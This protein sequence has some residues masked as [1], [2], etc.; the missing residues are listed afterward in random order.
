MPSKRSTARPQRATHSP[1][2]AV[3]TLP[4]IEERP[5]IRRRRVAGDTLR[6]RKE[7][8]LHHEAFD[9]PV[10]AESI[11]V[12]RIPCE[13]IIDGPLPSTRQE[14]D[15]LVIPVIEERYVIEKRLVVV[16]EVRIR[17]VFQ[18]RTVREH[19]SLLRERAVLERQAAGDDESGDMQQSPLQTDHEK[20]EPQ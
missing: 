19:V 2:E 14:G 6:V 3:R 7:R 9:V 13:L 17:R 8:E 18:E 1:R 11:E 15:T 20:E 16:E 5:R 10:C 12:E 4:L